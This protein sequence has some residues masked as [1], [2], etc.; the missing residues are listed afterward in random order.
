VSMT[1]TSYLNGDTATAAP[2]SAD[3]DDAVAA[4][5]TESKQPNLVGGIVGG[6]VAFL[7]LIALLIF[8]LRRRRTSSLRKERKL[9]RYRQ[10]HEG[11]GTGTA[12]IPLH[13]TSVVEGVPPEDRRRDRIS[14]QRG[15]YNPVMTEVESYT[16]ES[17]IL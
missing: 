3:E 10:V 6:I 12:A 7:V 8:L 5:S 16:D 15:P 9:G 13:W 1:S 17:G 4:L 2:F 14:P 11:V